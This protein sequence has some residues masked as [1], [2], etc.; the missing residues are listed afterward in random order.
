MIA[1]STIGVACIVIGCCQ[2]RMILQ[3]NFFPDFQGFQPEFQ[4]L[5]VIAQI[6]VGGAH[7]VIGSCQ[8]RM[9]HRQNLFSDF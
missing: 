4:S 6:T 7:T 2:I 8:I 5:V 3:Q 1:Q 9:I